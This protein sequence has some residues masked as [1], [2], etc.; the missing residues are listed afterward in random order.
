MNF[1]VKYKFHKYDEQGILLGTYVEITSDVGDNLT[2]ILQAEALN[3]S[4][5]ELVE[6]V[7]ENFYQR[8]YLNRAENE[9]ITKL[10]EAL[11]KANDTI[12]K[13]DEMNKVTRKAL[14]DISTTVYDNSELIEMIAEHVGFEIP[15]EEEEDEDGTSEQSNGGSETHVETEG[16]E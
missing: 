10:N 3:V 8:C 16:G 11:E 2:A 12:K 6:R 7:K 9:A 4:E 15:D 13:N 14:A 1:K 5:P